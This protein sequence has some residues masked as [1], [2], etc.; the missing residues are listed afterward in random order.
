MYLYPLGSYRGTMLSLTL[1]QRKQALANNFAWAL[2]QQ[3]RT[4][5]QHAALSLPGT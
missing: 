4:H 1:C 2:S 3:K 5:N